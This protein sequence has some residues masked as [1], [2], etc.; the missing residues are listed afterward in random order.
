M[1]TER[2]HADFIGRNECDRT[3]NAHRL[4]AFRKSPF[5]R[6]AAANPGQV[7]YHRRVFG[8]NQKFVFFFE[9]NKVS[10]IKRKSGASTR[11][12]ACRTAVNIN[13]CI[14][15]DAF[16]EQEIA[17]SFALIFNVKGFTVEGRSVSIAVFQAAGA[18]VF[19]PIVRNIDVFPNNRI[20]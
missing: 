11:V 19:I 5:G 17:F 10:N 9:I 1:H 12:P 6:A 14:G 13:G 16:K 7:G 20:G 2:L 4:R 3:K 8:S 15:A 18:F